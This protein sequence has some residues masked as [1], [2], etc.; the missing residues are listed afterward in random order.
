MRQL[1]TPEHYYR[2]RRARQLRRREVRLQWLRTV[3]DVA[4][5]LLLVGGLICI[6]LYKVVQWNRI[7]SGDWVSPGLSGLVLALPMLGVALALEGW[8]VRCR[9]AAQTLEEE[10]RAARAEPP[11]R[12]PGSH[13]PPSPLPWRAAGPVLALFLGISVIQWPVPPKEPNI[14]APKTQI[15]NLKNALSMYQ[16]DN[17]QAP[18]TQQGLQALLAPPSSAP[19][20]RHWKGPYLCDVTAVPRDPWGND[21]HYEAP[22]PHGESFYIVSYGEDGRPGGEGYAADVDSNLR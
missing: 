13:S 6:G 18:T 8:R 3:S 5:L 9:T 14:S 17:G 7:A 12:S 10:H 2:P 11:G 21:Y 4:G 22:G 19:R 16:V 20:P 15:A 1:P